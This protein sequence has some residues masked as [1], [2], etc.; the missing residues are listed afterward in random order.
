MFVVDFLQLVDD[1]LIQVVVVPQEAG[2]GQRVQP[3]VGAG[4]VP[5]PLLLLFCHTFFE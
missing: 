1:N 3:R 4:A 5:L 2:V